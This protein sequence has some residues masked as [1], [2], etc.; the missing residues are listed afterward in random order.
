MLEI[1]NEKD[2]G[3]FETEIDNQKYYVFIE[4]YGFDRAAYIFNSEGK[5][6][7]WIPTLEENLSFVVEIEKYYKE[8]VLNTQNLIPAI[9]DMNSD[10]YKKMMEEIER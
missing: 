10:V 5:C 7:S 3:F 9:M 2:Y 4:K 1:R 8:I 6:L